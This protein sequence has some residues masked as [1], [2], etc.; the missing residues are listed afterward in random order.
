MGA[1]A[2]GTQEE[3][4]DADMDGGQDVEME[5]V[6]KLEVEDSLGSLEPSVDD[7]VAGL[8]LQQLG[9]LG[10]RYRREARQGAK[11]I[12]SEVY[13]PPRVT[14]LLRESRM[15]HAVPGLALDLTV[16]DPMDG[17]PWDFS[18]AA[19]RRRARQLFAEQRPYI[20]IGSPECTHFC[21]FQA[22]NMARSKDVEAMKR[23]KTAAIVHLKFVAQLYADQIARGK[24]FL[25]EHPLRATSWSEDE[26]AKILQRPDVIRV[27]GDQCQYGA[28]VHSGKH[29]GKPILKPTGFMTN[30]PAVARALPLTC[31]GT[32]DAC[33]RRRGGQHQSCSGR[34]AREAAKY[35]KGLCRA[36]LKGVRDQLK[37][38]ELI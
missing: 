20:I 4:I 24:Y 16:N 18:I 26:I 15:R 22:M 37:E 7:F 13:S 6:G 5:F 35:P 14:K 29:A 23:A 31:Q 25:H 30:A 2:P 11:A 33:S 1:D 10:R 36:M 28:E 9:S 27:H 8:L 21:S 34:Y 19:K 12:V 17:T 32:W 38:D 3:T